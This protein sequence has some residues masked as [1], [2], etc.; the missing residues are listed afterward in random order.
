M[1]NKSCLTELQL[2]SIYNDG[3]DSLPISREPK[4]VRD[5]YVAM[6]DLTPDEIATVEDPTEYSLWME[7]TMNPIPLLCTL[8]AGRD[9]I[10]PDRLHY[11]AKDNPS[12]II[13]T[14]LHYYY[15]G[16]E[17]DDFVL[18]FKHLLDSDNATVEYQA[19]VQRA[20]SKPS[21]EEFG[22]EKGG[23]RRHSRTTWL[24]QFAGH[25]IVWFSDVYIYPSDLLRWKMIHR[26]SFVL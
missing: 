25:L 26:S 1:P 22:C 10:E 3:I 5:A 2:T 16:L 11:R 4:R 12:S 13:L 18:A 6:Q 8:L 23:K 14:S 7:S 19:R 21:E 20:L 17:D 9:R 24:V 15:T